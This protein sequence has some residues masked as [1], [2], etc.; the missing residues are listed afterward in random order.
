MSA[1]TETLDG[2]GDGRRLFGDLCYPLYQRLFDPDGELV[3]EVDRQLTEAKMAFTVEF[4]LS[5]ALGVSLVVGAVLWLCGLGLGLW[6]ADPIVAALAGATPVSG[7]FGG[8]G[9]EI[10]ILLVTVATGLT[11]GLGGALL[12][13]SA[14]VAIPY[15]R[16]NARRRE[17]NMLLPDAVSFMYAL[18]VGGLDQMAILE[19]I[20]EAEDTYGEVAREFQSIVLETE[21][22]DTDY[23]SAISDQAEQTP[24]DELSTFLLDMLSVSN[25]GGNMTRFLE[26]Q[27]ETQLR[28]AKQE[29]EQVLETLELFGEMFMTLSL[30]P[31]LLIIILLVMSILGEAQQQLLYMTIY[32]L[33]PLVGI[34]FLVLVA[35]VKQDDV[36]DGYLSV[37]GEQRREQHGGLMDLGPVEEFV[38]EYRVFDRI[39]RREGTYET[40]QLLAD[41]H[42]FFRDH[43]TYTLALTVPATAVL[44]SFAVLGG[45]LP[46]TW[47]GVV[48]APFRSTAGYVYLPLFGT[49]LPLAVF[50]EWNVH[51]RRAILDGLP[52]TLR[53]LAGANETG[54]TLLESIEVVADTGSNRLAAELATIHAKV[55]YGMR[56]EESLIR[57][58]NR[59]HVPRLARTVKLITRA[60]EASSQLST[61]LSTVAQ[62][63]EN[64]ADIERERRART[65]MQVVVIVMTYLTL[66]G[67]MAVLQT[68]FVDVMARLTGQAGT[69]QVAQFGEIDPNQVSLLFFH[70][71]TLQAV[72][73]GLTAGYIQSAD[74]LSGVK[75]VVALLTVALAVWGLLP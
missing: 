56:L 62:A 22:F 19:A 26:T 20:A 35:T 68:Q 61:V 65:R 45:V 55:A 31:L 18:S 6:L 28:T 17:I 43:P 51:S 57:F 73:S 75:Y 8:Y 67:V 34:G 29:Q 53:K 47:S 60:H 64:Q 70:A 39:K 63:A 44:L 25:S 3:A 48:D 50:H 21:Y 15:M 7:L 41:P 37:P 9:T 1:P 72:V 10:G 24:S 27:K 5:R 69:S 12:G 58:N 71:V 2:T 54:M 74:L 49:L 4:Y 23:R 52:D 66:L 38:G 11:I 30:F 32:G 46:T 33:I 14:V 16:A 40:L 59:Y 42:L 13:F 36:G